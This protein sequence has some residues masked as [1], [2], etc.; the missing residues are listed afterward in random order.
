MILSTMLM[1]RF[2]KASGRNCFR[3]GIELILKEIAWS[4]CYRELEQ[5]ESTLHSSRGGMG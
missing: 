2:T 1:L 5:P 3:A 4:G